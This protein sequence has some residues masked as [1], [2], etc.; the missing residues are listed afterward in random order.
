MAQLLTKKQEDY[1]VEKFTKSISESKSISDILFH[2]ANNISCKETENSEELSDSMRFM[3]TNASV[4]YSNT[5]TNPEYLQNFR[6]T[7]NEV[8]KEITKKY[9][10]AQFKLE[11]RRKSLVSSIE[12]MIKLLKQ[13]RSL[14][15]FRDTF[16]IRLVLMCT[17]D[18][19]EEKQR[20]LYEICDIIITFLI[21]QGYVLCEAD[22]PPKKQE[23]LD[24]DV[25]NIII[26]KVSNISDV[27]SRCIKDYVAFP[28]SNGYQSMQMVFRSLNGYYF[29]VQLRTENMHLRA[30]Y[31][32]ANH[33]D[34]KLS[35]YTSSPD[36]LRLLDKIDLSA[37]QMPGFRY[38]GFEN[39]KFTDY[40]G[41]A[42]SIKIYFRNH[43]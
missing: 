41:F 29:E 13:G 30:E 17:E 39:K 6:D 36:E 25:E 1:I 10:D 5:I 4:N 24:K 8:F 32:Y 21:K 19:E 35:E 2:F 16:G 12:K 11:G 37:I 40:I 9:P 15:L 28:K 14:D 7:F 43:P 22:N 3:L 20:E 42:E 27:H 26:P 33:A 38:I 31:L 34:Y 18:Q 23:K